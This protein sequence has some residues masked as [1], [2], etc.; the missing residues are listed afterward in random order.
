MSDPNHITILKKGIDV[1]NK[2]RADNPHW[3]STR[4]W[5]PRNQD[6]C[7][8]DT[9]GISWKRNVMRVH[10]KRP[11]FTESLVKW[12]P[13]IGCLT[14]RWTPTRLRCSVLRA[15]LFFCYDRRFSRITFRWS[16]RW[17]TWSLF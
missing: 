2:W 5:Q 10:Q 8:P 13:F 12:F 4:N 7:L 6:Q 16:P 17:S 11:E 1:W 3:R 9:L 15:A 14:M